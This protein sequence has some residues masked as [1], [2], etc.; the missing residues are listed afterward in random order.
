[1]KFEWV[2]AFIHQGHINQNHRGTTVHPPG[3]LKL[4]SMITLRA[5]EDMEPKEQSHVHC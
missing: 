1:M 3:W 2:I 5:G 4:K